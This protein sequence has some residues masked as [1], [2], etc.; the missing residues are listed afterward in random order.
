MATCARLYGLD[1]ETDTATDGLDPAVSAVLAVAVSTPWH[2][3]VLTGPEAELLA[4]L[5]HHLATLPRGVVVTWNGAAFDLPFIA[6]RA[7]R[8]GVVLGLRLAEDPGLTVRRPLPGHRAG[9]RATWHGHQHLDAY[10]LYRADVGR[11]LRVS[12]SLKSIARLVGLTPVEV[13]AARVHELSPDALASY[14]ASDA[15]LARQLLER[16]WNP[17]WFGP[18]GLGAP[19]P[20]GAAQR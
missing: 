9:Y 14:V 12:C 7:A 15:R 18:A 10:R 4:R 8:A 3:T 6:E 2:D 19:D 17:T 20:A 13:D 1:I 5:D 16:R 11:A